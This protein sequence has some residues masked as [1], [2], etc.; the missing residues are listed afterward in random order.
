M[1]AVTVLNQS[2]SRLNQVSVLWGVAPHMAIMSVLLT[3]GWKEGS[4][5]SELTLWHRFRIMCRLVLIDLVHNADSTQLLQ[6]CNLLMCFLSL[7]VTKFAK[8]ALTFRYCT[9][10]VTWCTL[11]FFLTLT[12]WKILLKLNSQIA[13]SFSFVCIVAR[14]WTLLCCLVKMSL[15]LFF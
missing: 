6:L 8:N 9:Y 4:M 7:F 11:I 1:E 5:G 12:R 15:Q 14:D 13:Y 2:P 10:F 3:R